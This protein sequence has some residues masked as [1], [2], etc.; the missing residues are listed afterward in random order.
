MTLPETPDSR[1]LFGDAARQSD[2]HE[3]TGHEN[4]A[5]PSTPESA[6]SASALPSRRALREA[7][8]AELAAG[9]RASVPAASAVPSVPAAS[10][11]PSVPV[12]PAAA[13][14]A[15]VVSATDVEKEMRVSRAQR[16]SRARQQRREERAAAAAAASSTGAKSW[17]Q[18]LSASGV[19]VV[20]AG[21][22]AT[23]ALPAYADNED[24]AVVQQRT[25]A[26]AVQTLAVDDTVAARDIKRDKYGATPAPDLR[27]TYTNTVQSNNIQTYVA[28]GARAQGDDYPWPGAL[29][30]DQG[31]TLSPLRYYYRECVDF[32][33]WRL[34]RDAGVTQAPWKW[35]WSTLTPGGGNA[36]AWA[37]AWAA[38]GWPTSNVPQAGAVAWFNGNHVAYVNK[39]NADGTVLL[40]EY[41]WGNDH[42]Y[43][44]RT[45]AAS[46]VA[47]YLY[48]P[49]G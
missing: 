29:T 22:F 46:E 20:V 12:A 9:R 37:G 16:F 5:R 3:N 11:V 44:Q 17:R 23:L 48:A 19:M 10:A 38:K 4:H 18:R 32:V 43:H 15:A 21:L 24:P 35:D 47:L 27:V 31:G 7:A 42:S 25:A 41:N 28:S 2:V 36:S 49:P 26:A 33:A 8:A 30:D 13:Q 34:N 45:V 6:A 1:P 14:H 39:V 40:E